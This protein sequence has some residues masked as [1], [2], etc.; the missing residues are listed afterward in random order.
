LSYSAFIPVS[1]DRIEPLVGIDAALEKLMIL[2]TGSNGR[3]RLFEGPKGEIQ[4]IVPTRRSVEIHNNLAPYILAALMG[5]RLNAYVEDVDRGRYFRVPDC[6]WNGRSQLDLLRAFAGI[7][8]CNVPG[9][10]HGMEGQP[11][12][13]SQADVGAFAAT[14]RPTDPASPMPPP[15]VEKKVRGWGIAD[16]PLVTEM[17]ALVQCGECSSPSAAA[18]RLI[19]R[20]KGAGTPESKVRRL[21][22]A[23]YEKHPST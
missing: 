2:A 15:P 8:E 11:I 21:V 14:M 20:A 3:I 18:S 7:E 5:G 22:T 19:S 10:A 23:Y 12:V 1:F 6:Y 9:Y 13:L 17:R 16:A 4:K